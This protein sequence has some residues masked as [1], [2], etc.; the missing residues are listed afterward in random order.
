[1][2]DIRGLTAW[3]TSRPDS[4]ADIRGLAVWPTSRPGSMADI[5]GLAVWLTSR[6]SS[7]AEIDDVHIDSAA[8]AE[9]CIEGGT[10]KLSKLPKVKM[11]SRSTCTDEL[12]EGTCAVTK[13]FTAHNNK[14]CRAARLTRLCHM[15]CQTRQQSVRHCQC[16]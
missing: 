16:N 12:S 8:A 2:A 14:K 4:M 3:L 15:T 13:D 6:P 9:R 1:M 7:V 10:C 11:P 5:R